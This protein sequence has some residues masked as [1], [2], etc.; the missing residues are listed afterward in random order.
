VQNNQIRRES[1]VREIK[2]ISFSGV[3]CYLLTTDTGFVLIDTGYSKNRM[4]VTREL[5]SS[6]CTY[7]TLQ[8]ILLTHG[9]F[10]HSGNAAYLREKYTV[11]IVMHI[12]DEGMV[13][14]GDLFYNRN[15]QFP[16]ENDWKNFVVFLKGRLEEG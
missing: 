11:K 15:S 13:E 1:I 16:G 10:D 8:L 7:E 6:G 9:D 2:T 14:K 4:D 3:N 12:D 5:E